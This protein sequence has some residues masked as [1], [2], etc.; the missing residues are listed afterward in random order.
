MVYPILKRTLDIVAAVVGITITAP[1]LI[2]VA[3][4]VKLKDRGPVF[5]RGVRVGQFGRSF[6]LYKFRSMVVKADQ[7]GGPSTSSDDPRVTQLG[8]ILRRYKIDEIPQLINVLVGEMSLVGPRPEVPDEVKLY[9]EEEM[10]LLSVRPGI[11]D[12]AS[13]AFHDEGE[14]LRGYEDP[15]AAYRQLIRPGKIALGLEYVKVRSLSTDMNILLSTLKILVISRLGM[16]LS[17]R[18][19]RAEQRTRR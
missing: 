5:Y 6:R 3:L 18:S 13:I 1:L 15:H 7:I 19:I 8:A 10:Q 14:I 16:P 11:T 12:Y 9:T 2:L 17:V 4:L